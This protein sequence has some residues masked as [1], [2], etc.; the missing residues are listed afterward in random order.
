M[1]RLKKIISGGQTGADMAALD[2]GLRKGVSVGG[3][4][5]K[6]R[7]NESGTIAAFYPLIECISK[8]Y[9]VRTEKNVVDSDATLIF[10]S[11]GKIDDGTQLCID[12]CHLHSKKFFVFNIYNID[13]L[14]IDL[15]IDWLEESE[16]GILNIAGNRESTLPG[17]YIKTLG[18]LQQIFTDQIY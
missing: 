6:G 1:I 9:S 12:F 4:C 8:Q 10:T 17:I 14:Q 13:S 7:I 11:G 5:P 3:W 16:V 15:V 18:F 2:F